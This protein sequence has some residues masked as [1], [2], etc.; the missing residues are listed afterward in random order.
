MF[1]ALCSP[2]DDTARLAAANRHLDIRL[3]LFSFVLGVNR[4]I[5]RVWAYMWLLITDLHPPFS[6]R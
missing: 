2:Q 6:L 5:L 1:A 3:R 4:W